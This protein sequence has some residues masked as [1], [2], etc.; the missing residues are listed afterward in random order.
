MHAAD[1][2]WSPKQKK[3]IPRSNL[4]VYQRQAFRA[5]LVGDQSANGHTAGTTVF[6]DES[7]RIWHQD[8]EVLI[9]SFKTKMHVIGA[10]VT[11]GIK[12]AIE[13]AEKNFRFS[14]LLTNEK[15]L[16]KR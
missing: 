8:D 7:V 9:L 13:E 3:N 2:S 5:A 12:Q 10:G 4:P 16:C 15:P 14:L 11:A 1:G 6:E